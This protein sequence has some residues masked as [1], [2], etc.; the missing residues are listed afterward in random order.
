[1][2]RWFYSKKDTVEDYRALR[3]SRLK[4]WGY[5]SNG[6]RFGSVTWSWGN[7][8]RSGISV[9]TSISGKSG[10]ARLM[11]TNTNSWT[12]EKIDLDYQVQLVTTPC[13]YGDFRWWFICPLI[14]N[15]CPCN[16]RVGVLFLGVGK[17]AGCR[18]CYDLTYTSCQDS[19]K[20]DAL[21]RSM[22]LP[23]ETA[24]KRA[25]GW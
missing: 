24:L 22:G 6:G 3:I 9:L 17:Y 16:R 19:H 7:E 11:Y 20:F 18:H 12:G 25:M 23:N 1:M 5:L 10:T 4:T 14:K 21:A 2:G 15:C 8:A 13:N